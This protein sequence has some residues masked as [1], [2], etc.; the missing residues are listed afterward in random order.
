MP[1]HAHDRATI[2]DQ[3]LEWKRVEVEQAKRAQ[4]LEAVRFAARAGPPPRDL[5]AALRAPGVSLIAEIKRASPSRGLLYADLDAAAQAV[6][7]ERHGAVAISVLTDARFFQGALDDLRV[8]RRA[9]RIPVLRKEFVLD[10]YQVYQARAAGADAILLIVAAL[11]DDT[12]RALYDLTYKLGMSALVEVHDK[13][14]LE[15][16]R[17]LTPHILGIN[18]RNLHTFEVSLDVTARLSALAPRETLLVAESGIHSAADV[19]RLAALGVHGM[20]VG[21]SLVRAPD[22]GAKIQELITGATR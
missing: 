17:R 1:T 15:R 13:A 20:L 14:E 19:E 9:V 18:N 5:A 8:A 10:A 2:L 11:D 22:L 6:A 7:Y 4:P 16:A 3:I 12:L 21:E